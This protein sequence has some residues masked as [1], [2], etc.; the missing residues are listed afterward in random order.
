METFERYKE[1]V[2]HWNRNS[3]DLEL[4]KYLDLLETLKKKKDLKDSVMNTVLDRTQVIESQAVGGRSPCIY[5][6]P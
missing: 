5:L 1:Q 2:D 4:N 3:T 6:E